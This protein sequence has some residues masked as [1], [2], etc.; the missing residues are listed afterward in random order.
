MKLTPKARAV[1]TAALRADHHDGIGARQVAHI[2]GYGNKYMR[3]GQYVGKLCKEGWI[4]SRMNWYRGSRGHD[5]YSHMSYFI[6]QK[7]K[8]ILYK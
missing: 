3:A 8:E 6:T 1:L 2:L 7:G 5:V 4:Q